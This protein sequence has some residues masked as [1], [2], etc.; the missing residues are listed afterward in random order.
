MPRNR[1]G[2][3]ITGILNCLFVLC[4]ILLVLLIEFNLG[5]P[6]KSVNFSIDES[7][8]LHLFEDISGNIES[9]PQN[10]I[11]QEEDMMMYE[12]WNGIGGL[13]AESG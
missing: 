9:T 2:K 10:R 8:L 12:D 1:L 3:K 5:I 7:H 4:I 6:S 13:V 11:K